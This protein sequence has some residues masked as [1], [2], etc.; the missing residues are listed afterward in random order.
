M[1]AVYATMVLA[2]ALG[3]VG[4]L[5]WVR[6]HQIH[7]ASP[8]Q[9]QALVDATRTEQVIGAVSKSLT[10]VLSYDYAEPTRTQTAA[11]HFLTGKARQQERTLFEALQRKAPGQNLVLAASVQ[12]AGVVSLKPHSATLLVFLDQ[13]SQRASEKQKSISAAQL[14]VSATLVGGQ[15]KVD[16][17]EPL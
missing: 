10:A 6:A 7:A 9:N 15:W 5:G 12:A 8:A 11:D 3:A 17:L 14:R 1:R 16:G 2:I 4:V 13:S